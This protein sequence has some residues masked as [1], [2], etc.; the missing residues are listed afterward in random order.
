M[1][2]KVLKLLL[3]FIAL[4]TITLSVKAIDPNSYITSENN[5]QTETTE[6]QQEENTQDD[7]EHISV[8][9]EKNGYKIII[10]DNAKLLSNEEIEKL[11]E[12]MEPLTEY[13]H[14]AFITI[15]TNNTTTAY[16]AEDYY[17]EKFNQDSGTLLMIDMANREVY[18]FS[19]GANYN[20]ITKG[21]AYIITDN[22]YKYATNKDYYSC[23][24]VAFDQINTLLDGGKIL[25]PM[26]YIS[27]VVIAIVVAF[28]INFFIVVGASKIKKAG[29]NEVI[30]TC[31]IEF[32]ISN[33]VGKR[34]GTRRKYSP[35][36]ESSGSSYHSGGGG[37]FS[38]GGGGGHSGGGGGHSF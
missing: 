18:I 14:I 21:K 4:F 19:D 10:E 28:F 35:V 1:N 5:E 13:G 6:S 33:V 17:H 3:V 36:S 32:Q 38:G 26:R 25:E 37:G 16:Y 11:K 24:T 23:A 2:K 29:T 20:V 9:E 34:T 7:E 8:N 15:D 30:N 27:N 31:D 22:I 12:K